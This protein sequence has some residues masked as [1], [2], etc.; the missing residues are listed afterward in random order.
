MEATECG[1]D[2]D[3]FY[4]TILLDVDAEVLV[5]VQDLS[6]DFF[7]R[8]RSAMG[9]APSHLSGSP[10]SS[11]SSL[12]SSTTAALA[13]SSSVISASPSSALAAAASSSRAV[14]LSGSSAVTT[15]AGSFSNH[16]GSDTT[17]LQR[18]QATLTKG[19]DHSASLARQLHALRRDTLKIS[20]ETKPEEF[21]LRGGKT[22]SSH[23]VFREI[24]E[25]AR[26][27]AIRI[28]RER[29]R[30]REEQERA[31]QEA[32]LHQ[33]EQDHTLSSSSSSS[34]STTVASGYPPSSLSSLSSSS[35]SSSW[36]AATTPL[37]PKRK[38]DPSFLLAS[39]VHSNKTNRT[40]DPESP[41]LASSTA[42]PC[43]PLRRTSSATSTSQLAEVPRRRTTTT[44]S[45]STKRT[46][47]P[48]AE[49]TAYTR[50]DASSA[51]VS[52]Q[53]KLFSKV[54]DD[55]PENLEAPEVDTEM[56]VD[57]AHQGIKESN[58]YFY[59]GQRQTKRKEDNIEEIRDLLNLD[60]QR[61]RELCAELDDEHMEG[62]QLLHDRLQGRM[63]R[64]LFALKRGYGL[65]L[66][67]YGS[68]KKLLEDFVNTYLRP[69]QPVL[70][71]NGYFPGPVIQQLLDLITKNVMGTTRSF[72]NSLEQCEFIKRYFLDRARVQAS[73]SQFAGKLSLMGSTVSLSP[74][75][76]T[77]LLQLY[78]NPDAT[79]SKS[80]SN[81]VS[82]SSSSSSSLLQPNKLAT[83]LR[84][85]FQHYHIPRHLY[86][87]VHCIERISSS[88]SH[89][90]LSTLASLPQ[91][92]M[93]ASV[94][95]LNSPLRV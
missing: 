43:S 64:W 18:V 8:F 76:S 54:V 46:V 30:L 24:E 87:V 44:Q 56:A 77:C 73:S 12:P 66:H 4:D 3:E 52:S 58:L 57:D 15:S 72:S 29:R 17:A 60:T 27:D 48:T 47:H 13:L 55:W 5:T 83:T 31:K 90:I 40:R 28:R 37:K 11:V 92:H 36:S 65:L 67:G 86:I 45:S 80:G 62:K 63:N 81:P 69:S 33:T 61:L 94:D 50:A 25:K 20:V 42:K 89:L 2:A 35:A 9:P 74:P 26:Q 75:R 85:V 53:G 95:H 51:S 79:V 93:M 32:V 41:V 49:H 7:V 19:G 1:A 23:A 70:I 71:V 21:V 38:F 39:D 22:K 91:V 82:P 59:Q 88:Q 6:E 78:R 68:K 10:P 84:G 14:V 34:S 16:L